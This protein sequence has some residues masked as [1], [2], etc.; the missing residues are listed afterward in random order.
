MTVTQDS[1]A[2]TDVQFAMQRGFLDVQACLALHSSIELSLNSVDAGFDSRLQ[3]A[4]C[5]EQIGVG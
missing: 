3:I 4:Q 5:L 2:A 1:A